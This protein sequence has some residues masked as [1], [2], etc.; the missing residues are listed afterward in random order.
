MNW[1]TFFSSKGDDSDIKIRGSSA[2]SGKS[3]VQGDRFTHT[4]DSGSKSSHTH[5]SYKSDHDSGKYTEYRG[6]ENSGDRGY[7][8]S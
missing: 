8:K 6:G 1:K 4:G 3:V 7:N 5:E 2:D